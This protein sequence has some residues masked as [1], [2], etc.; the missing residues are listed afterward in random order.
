MFV[1]ITITDSSFNSMMYFS[2]R[3][4]LRTEYCHFIP[5]SHNIDYKYG[6]L[7]HFGNFRRAVLK[8]CKNLYNVNTKKEDV[9]K[10]VKQ[11]GPAFIK[12][13]KAT[14]ADVKRDGDDL[15]NREKICA[16][17]MRD[18]YMKLEK[19]IERKCGGIA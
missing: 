6:N 12:E 2:F 15:V 5:A 19:N 4:K 17:N 3:T 1:A 10:C 8:K 7:V 13:Q 11:T 18:R 16:K 9:K 14:V